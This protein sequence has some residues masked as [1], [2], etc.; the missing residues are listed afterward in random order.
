M[1][2]PAVGPDIEQAISHTIQLTVSHNF[3]PIILACVII[4]FAC[5]AVYKPTRPRV[6]ILIGSSL[7]LLHFE[8]VKHIL[9]ALHA[10][11]QV[12][13]TTETPNYTF[14][15]ITEKILVRAVPLAIAMLGWGSLIAALFLAKR[16]Q[17]T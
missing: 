6:L 1:K 5:A 12:T 4:A 9:P 17:R 7:I 10:Q 11:T 15:W 8:Y 3:V 13:L 2:I 16:S 14:I